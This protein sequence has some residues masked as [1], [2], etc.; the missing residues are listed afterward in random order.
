MFHLL[1]TA[2]AALRKGGEVLP[3]RLVRFM[4]GIASE[5]RTFQVT[6]TSFYQRIL[7]SMHVK[8]FRQRAAVIRKK[9]VVPNLTGLEQKSR[10]LHVF[11]A[12]VANAAQVCCL[13]AAQLPY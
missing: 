13:L 9:I 5:C 10:L 4:T 2:C 8:V 7:V 1:M 11:R 6:G 12:R 3:L